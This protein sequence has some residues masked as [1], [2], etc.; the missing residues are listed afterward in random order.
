MRDV[1]SVVGTHSVV[2]ECVRRR[3]LRYFQYCF[4]IVKMYFTREQ[5]NVII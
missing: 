4:L 3:V 5:S 1:F 2:T